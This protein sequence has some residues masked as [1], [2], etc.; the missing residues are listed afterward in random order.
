MIDEVI[1]SVKGLHS[2]YPVVEELNDLLE[3]DR[4]MRKALVLSLNTAVSSAQN[5][6]NTEL[7]S[8]IN[9]VFQGNGWP[10]TIDNY[11]NYLD[12]Y[13]RLIPNEENDPMY[14]NAWKSNGEKNGYNQKVYDLLCQFYWLVD[15]KGETSD[16]TLQEYPKF[17]DWLVKFVRT[18]GDFLDSKDSLTKETLNSFKHD[19]MYNFPLYSEGEKNWETFNQFFYREF[20]KADEVTGITPLRPIAEPNNNKTIVAA[21]DCTFKAEYPIDDKGNVL[22]PDGNST[23]LT[24]KNTHTIGTIAEL[25]DGSEYASDFY[26]GTFVHYFLSP[27]DYHRFHTPVRGKLLE[28]KAILGKVFLDVELKDDGQWDAPDNAIDGYEFTQARGLII[29]DTGSPVGKIA[30][31]PIGMA[32]VSGVDMYTD[33][34]EIGQEVI[35]GQEFGKFKFGGSDIIML[36]QKNPDLYLFKNDPSQNGIHFQY[37]QTA[38]YWNL[39]NQD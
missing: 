28:L 11:L 21:A 10:T 33:R 1:K 15:Q 5:Q 35:K 6:L 31:L 14:P 37:G 27:F 29:V 9:R 8:A 34:L 39:D 16:K 2:Y 23:S 12:L 17:A 25:L 20:N 7:Y 36:F 38:A 22:G 32:Q 30:V 26:G 24:L 4:G 3:E 13:V 19:R 18:W